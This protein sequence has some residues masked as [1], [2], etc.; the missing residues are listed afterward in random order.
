M[1][2]HVPL[3]ESHL[4]TRYVGLTKSSPK[5][6]KIGAAAWDKTRAAAEVATL[7]YAAELLTLHAQRDQN[8]GYTFP[9]DHP[10][11]ATF[12]G[13]FPFTETPDQL[14]AIEATKHD[15]EA[16]QA[17]GSLNLRGCWLW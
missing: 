11:Q 16:A 10:W 12:E 1:T 6:G 8:G 13:A 7:D 17:D 9:P 14:T 5:L 4:L 15:M 2:V 3:H